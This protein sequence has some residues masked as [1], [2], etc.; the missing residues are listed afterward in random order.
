MK[1]PAFHKYYTINFAIYSILVQFS[2]FLLYSYIELAEFIRYGVWIQTLCY[3][4]CELIRYI[5][6]PITGLMFLLEIILRKF[7]LLKIENPVNI[8][9]KTQKNIYIITIIAFLIYTISMIYYINPIL[10]K[11]L[12]LD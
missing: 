8:S 4:I 2:L 10:N 11:A 3:A 9:K 12:E 1:I 7:N 6:L 5:V